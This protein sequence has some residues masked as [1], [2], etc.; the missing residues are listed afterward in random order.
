LLAVGSSS[1]DRTALTN[2]RWLELMRIYGIICSVKSPRLRRSIHTVLRRIRRRAPDDF[3]RIR[4]RVREFAPSS[5]PYSVE[6]GGL[7]YLKEVL[8]GEVKPHFMASAGFIFPLLDSPCVIELAE[9]T[10][11]PTTTVA[12]ELGHVC[13]RS[14]DLTILC[15]LWTRFNRQGRLIIGYNVSELCADLY[16]Y[17]WGFGRSLDL[18]RRFARTLIR[19]IMRLTS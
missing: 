4:Q 10:T 7:P 6:V 11:Q 3:K 8:H 1:E 14:L 12:H 16:A 13:T 15:L 9:S 5:V 17:K 2:E 18:D 19:G